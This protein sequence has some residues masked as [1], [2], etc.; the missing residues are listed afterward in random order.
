MKKTITLW[1][2]VVSMFF[3]A[4]VTDANAQERQTTPKTKTSPDV[5]TH[6]EQ[7]AK[8]VTRLP[9]QQMLQQMSNEERIEYL[10]NRDQGNNRHAGNPTE[11]SIEKQRM[12]QMEQERNVQAEKEKTKTSQ[13]VIPPSSENARSLISADEYST[14]PA[15]KKAHIDQNP[16]LYIIK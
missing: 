10:R 7:R 16:Q 5:A 3:A 6:Q 8:E 1:S 9:E 13:P 4:A 11:L 14:M 2:I 15:H 12:L